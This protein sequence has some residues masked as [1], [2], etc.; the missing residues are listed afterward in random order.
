VIA[1]AI[2]IGCT[3]EQIPTGLIL[4]NELNTTDT[5]YMITSIPAAQEKKIF[6]EEA[7]GVRCANCPTGADILR[8]LKTTYSD[9]IVSV[10]VYSPFLNYFQP[11]AKYD[12]NNSDDST[13]VFFLNNA[14]PT[15]PTAA[16][17]RLETGGLS[18]Y[19]FDK[20]QWAA[21][22]TGILTK[23][24]PLNIDLT[25][26]PTGTMDEFLVSAKIT[27]TDTIT[28]NLGISLY[29]I[30]DH[31][32]DYQDSL[33]FA[34]LNYEHNHILRKIITPISGSSFLGSV[35]TKEKGRVFEKFTTFT[36]PSLAV[37][38]TSP[39]GIVN[40]A[41]LKLICFVHK[42]GSSKEVIHAEEIDL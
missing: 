34:V 42:T 7:T 23:K 19:F 10:S 29:L 32:Y 22:V 13:L 1:I 24:T 4:F 3:K 25:A 14:D 28:A 11:P 2:L 36:L 27:F 16:I 5:T 15:K 33:S 17:D 41:N 35:N 31:V 6:V 12:F 40:K 8:N 26:T 39:V 37:L 21:I 9:K 38:G 30:E 18:K 20:S